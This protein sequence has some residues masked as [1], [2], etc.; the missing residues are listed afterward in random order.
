MIAPIERDESR[1]GHSRAAAGTVVL[2]VAHPGHEIRVHGWLESARPQVHVLTDGAGR[3]GRSRLAATEEMLTAAG[4]SRG[5]VFGR[6]GDAALYAALLARRAGTFIEIAEELARALVAAGAGMV[7]GDA[8]DGYNPSHD[9]C[10]Y[11]IDAATA[12]AARELGRPIA[13]YDFPLVGRPDACPARLEARALRIRLD[14]AAFARKVAVARRHPDLQAEVAAALGTA[15]IDAFRV[16]CLRPVEPR[17]EPDEVPPF[18]ERHG[19]R[20]ATEGHYASVIRFAEHVA[21]I[22]RALRERAGAARP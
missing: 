22:A 20:R 21:P 14:E 12:L 13:S 7:V 15:G 17:I 6:L 1:A 4:A 16:E 9:V 19:E 3:T 5:A 2:V 18:Y 10:R 8:L 11:L